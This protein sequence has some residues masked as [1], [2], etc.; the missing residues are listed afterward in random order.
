MSHYP[1][2]HAVDDVS[3]RMKLAV[4]GGALLLA[5]VLTGLFL[6]TACSPHP[7]PAHGAATTPS[8]VTPQPVLTPETP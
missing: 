3:D 1:R 4:N 5:F 2:M 7:A 6:L 8:Y